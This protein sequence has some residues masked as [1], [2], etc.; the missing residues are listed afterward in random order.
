VN[1]TVADAPFYHL[2]SLTSRSESRSSLARPS[3]DSARVETPTATGL[4]IMANKPA[5]MDPVWDDLDRYASPLSSHPTPTPCD[6]QPTDWVA[7]QDD[8]GSLVWLLSKW[9]ELMAFGKGP[10]IHDGL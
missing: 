1:A 10:T 7:M 9:T 8:G 4:V 6:E 3:T 5:Q 2:S